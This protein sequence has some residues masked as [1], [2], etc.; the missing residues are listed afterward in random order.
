MNFEYFT[1]TKVVFGKET[2]T[3]V[4]E[5]IRA[6]GGTKVLVHY[7]S[8]SVVRSGL[9]D[10]IC[11][12]LK[13]ENLPYVLLGG[14]VPNPR[15]SK[16]REGIRLCQ[17][18]KIDFLLAVGGGS[19]IDSAKAI[20]YG[21]ANEGDV[22]D[23]YD[24]KREATGCL[25]IGAVLTIAAAGSEMSDSSVITNEEGWIKRGYS[26]DYCRCRFAIMNPELTYTLPD[27]QTQSGCVDIMMHTMERYFNRSD[28]M[29]LTDGISEA[30]IRTV[31]KNAKILKENPKDYNA[32]AEVMWASSL[33]HN[34]L[35]GCGTD[36][37]DW[38]SHQIEHELGGMFDVAHGAG[39]AAVWGSWARYVYQEHPTRFASFAKQVFGV[40]CGEDEKAAALAGIE[41]MEA[42]YRS[43]GMPTSLTE[44]GIE[45][46]D[47][48]I[49]EMAEKCS[50]FGRRTVGVIKKLDKEDVA[51]IY[52]M[53][54]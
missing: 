18:E 41:A 31:M 34:G 48:Q 50:F 38:A 3:K 26:S 49:E 45:P 52:R 14:V 51:A 19:V 33:S 54:R 2:E 22:W 20:G 30:L 32:R 6:Q 5:L 36:G 39:L 9:L 21:M 43:V 15:L 29:E 8:G 37:G 10:R 12:S 17:E 53:A 16:V 28:N 1:P 7:G 11:D 24:R 47:A 4:G 35:T 42:F 25:P 13:K 40:D 44:L 23:F 27:Y 46:T